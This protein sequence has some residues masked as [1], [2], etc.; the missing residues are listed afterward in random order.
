MHEA[1][2]KRVQKKVLVGMLEGKRP[3]G[4]HTRRWENNIKNDLMK[5]G[6]EGVYCIYLAEDRDRWRALV[7]TVMNLRVAYKSGNLLTS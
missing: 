3:L 7:N 5:I 1:D 6:C 4:R 2:E